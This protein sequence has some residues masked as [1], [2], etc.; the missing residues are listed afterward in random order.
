MFTTGLGAS[1]FM[2]GYRFSLKQSPVPGRLDSS[3]WQKQEEWGRQ[4]DIM[5]CVCIYI[6]I[7]IFFKELGCVKHWKSQ[8]EWH[9]PRTGNVYSIGGRLVRM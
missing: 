8:A 1:K 7:Y 3:L 9:V 2:Q 6:T 4:I 5:G